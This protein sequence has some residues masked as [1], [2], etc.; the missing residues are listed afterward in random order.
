MRR[1][2]G[3]Y[4]NL[5]RAAPVRVFEDNGILYVDHATLARAPVVE[6]SDNVLLDFAAAYYP[7][8]L[9][10]FA[11]KHGTL[12]NID[13]ADKLYKMDLESGKDAI[14]PRMETLR[15]AFAELSYP[16]GKKR[17]VTQ[18]FKRI[19]REC[20]E[21]EYGF[22]SPDQREYLG[23]WIAARAMVQEVLELLG[24]ASVNGRKGECPDFVVNLSNAPR[25]RA[26]LTN[27]CKTHKTTVL[28][29][30]V[31]GAVEES[32][33]GLYIDG[34]L[35]RCHAP[36][37]SV[38]DVIS[39]LITVHIEGGIIQ[40]CR[41]LELH[42]RFSHLLHVIWYQIAE[43]INK[44]L[45]IGWCENERCGNV[46]LKLRNDEKHAC[47]ESCQQALKEGR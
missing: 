20:I 2:V 42:E 23:D 44:R 35:F 6:Y 5:N 3:D 24:G 13:A 28:A 19:Q 46:M 36:N 30:H 25:Y 17:K 40:E 31:S 26:F 32:V 22:I 39:E 41:N 29:H 18:D 9:L 27:A 10:E 37:R 4:L 34:N 14:V 33:T 11:E 45:V 8:H 16:H 21:R 12:F 1:L 15:V 7:K 38:D 47:C 43:Q